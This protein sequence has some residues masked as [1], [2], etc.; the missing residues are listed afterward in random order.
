MIK[1]VLVILAAGLGLRYGDKKPKQ[2]SMICGHELL[3]WS[4]R[5]ML[6]TEQSDKIVLVLDNLSN[7]ISDATQRYQ[8]DVIAGGEDRAH[9]F[10][11]ALDHIHSHYPDCEKVIFHEA[12]RPLV[13]HALIDK[14][15]GLLDEYD[16]IETCHRIVDSLGS[17]TVQ[18]PR[19]ED[20]Y[21]IQA[22]EAYRLEVL[23]KYYDCESQI[24]F[25]ANQFPK[26]C[27]GFQSFEL[28]Q[29]YKLTTKDDR[30]II[31]ALLSA[32]TQG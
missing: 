9:S 30:K 27:K 3:D 6:K 23:E 17:Y 12:A 24:Y 32:E 19:R 5:E 29:N 16:Y 18:A 25:A 21:L 10:Q 26:E 28:K 2:Y 4:M 14:Y 1:N 11:R 7:H 31:E 15:F 13:K 22:P 20:Y 8:V